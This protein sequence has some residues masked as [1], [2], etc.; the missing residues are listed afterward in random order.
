MSKENDIYVS[1]NA[2]INL[3]IHVE[4]GNI[5]KGSIVF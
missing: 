5:L 2:E 1:S 3:L 4:L